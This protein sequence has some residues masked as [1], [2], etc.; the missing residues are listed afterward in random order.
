[1]TQVEKAKLF[2]SLYNVWSGMPG[3]GRPGLRPAPRPS[4]PAAGRSPSQGC[5]DGEVIPLPAEQV[6]ARIAAVV[7][8]PL[9]LDFEG[10]LS[11]DRVRAAPLA[12][13]LTSAR[14]LRRLS[15][16]SDPAQEN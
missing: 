4:R 9:T 2:A 14:G 3:R 8:A 6:V 16:K 7:D 11:Y 12:P 5:R 15:T 1:M 13:D 10:T